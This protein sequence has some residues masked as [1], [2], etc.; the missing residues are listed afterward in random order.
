LAGALAARLEHAI[1]TVRWPEA[2]QTAIQERARAQRYRLLGYWAEERGLDAIATGHH[3]DDQAET[4]IM[5]LNRGAGV[6]GLA[7]VRASGQ[8]TGGRV[9]RPLL[10]W[11]RA[12]LAAIV[13]AAGIEPVADPS[14]VDD[15][16]DRARLRKAL[17]GVDWLDPQGIAAS[18]AA[19]ADSEE[20]LDWMVARLEGERIT[21]QGGNLLLDPRDVPFEIVRRLVA[22]CLR[23]IDPDIE[24]RGS[25]LVRM[26]KM[27]ESG[28][29]ATIGGVS[30]A[31]LAKG[32]WR[33][34]QAPP[35]RSH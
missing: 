16:Y 5:R 29:A 11:R 31:P 21:Q 27:L 10:G 34:R 17:A 7:G 1:L 3:A 15:R 4:L 33:F 32:G 30:A 13:A 9:I 18:A 20:A 6:S 12:E 24:I 2:P 25:A 14:N 23:R 26:V 19:L 8:G 28:H 35:R 22:L